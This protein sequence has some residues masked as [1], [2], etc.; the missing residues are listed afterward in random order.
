M[1]KKSAFVLLAFSLLLVVAG[2]NSKKKAELASVK[3]P[4]SGAQATAILGYN[5]PREF[6]Q[7]VGLRAAAAKN[8]LIIS[9]LNNS[10]DQI[11]LGPKS[12]RIL[13][14]GEMVPLD[15][16]NL[17]LSF[18]PVRTINPGE[19]AIFSVIVPRFE[20]M[21]DYKVAMNYPPKKILLAVPIEPASTNTTI[22]LD[23]PNLKPLQ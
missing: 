12:F 19:S 13:I 15:Q 6:Q 1:N 16:G 23:E 18:F 11:I 2:C 10:S 14:P 8:Q 7:S 5:Q 9:V 17:D 22:I 4:A 3:P 21:N 20:T